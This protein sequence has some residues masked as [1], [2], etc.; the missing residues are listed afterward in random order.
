MKSGLF[1]KIVDMCSKMAAVSFVLKAAVTKLC[2]LSSVDM[3][4]VC[5]KKCARDLS[6]C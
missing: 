6:S 3:F 5:W 4:A 1:Q 2:M